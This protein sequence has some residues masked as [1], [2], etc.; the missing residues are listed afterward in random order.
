MKKFFLGAVAITAFLCSCDSSDD[1]RNEQ[2][3]TT[4]YKERSEN[5]KNS[6]ELY[7]S[8]IDGFLYD[9]TQNYEDNILLFEQYVNSKLITDEYEKIELNQLAILSKADLS[10]IY[11]LNYSEEFIYS[12]FDILENGYITSN[13][14]ENDDELKLYST[15]SS[16]HLNGNGDDK[17]W[18]DKRTIAF[19]YGSQFNIKMAI[20]YAGAIEL[21]TKK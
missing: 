3:T 20:L 12:L 16:L 8:I 7:Q 14:I 18:N 9:R 4:F 5:N 2:E 10:Y 15:L 13:K 1:Y 17:L 21:S 19:A 11:K 6:Y